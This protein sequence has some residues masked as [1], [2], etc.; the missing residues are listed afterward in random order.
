M[1]NLG[2]ILR[3][4]FPKVSMSNVLDNTVA[5]MATWNMIIPEIEPGR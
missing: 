4:T 1:K 5:I 3:I 2:Q